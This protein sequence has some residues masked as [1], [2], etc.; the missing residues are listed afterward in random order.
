MGRKRK[1]RLPGTKK[2]LAIR[3]LVTYMRMTTLKNLL[4]RIRELKAAH[5]ALTRKDRDVKPL[6]VGCRHGQT[7]IALPVFLGNGS[8][9]ARGV[10]KV[11]HKA[12]LT[13]GNT[14]SRHC[15]VLYRDIDKQLAVC[16]L[17]GVD[18][19]LAAV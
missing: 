3:A 17:D 1:R 14:K 4:R 10:R 7:A 2:L 16:L 19:H 12:R 13:H 5:T 15:A 9:L 11:V 18:T 6:S 8:R